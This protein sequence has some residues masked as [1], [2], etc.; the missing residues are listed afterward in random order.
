MQ[1]SA[2]RELCGIA[3]DITGNRVGSNAFVPKRGGGNDA[4]KKRLKKYQKK[5]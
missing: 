1:A 5:D 3:H 4:S 2:H